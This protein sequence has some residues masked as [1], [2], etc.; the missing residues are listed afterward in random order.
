MATA[1]SFS[2]FAIGVVTGALQVEGAYTPFFVRGNEQILI[3]PTDDFIM[4]ETAE[5][6]ADP[7]LM[8]QVQ[9][10]IQ[11]MEQGLAIPWEDAKRNLGLGARG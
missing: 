1:T 10:G 5:I 4:D 2:W 11:E 9:R 7:A 3:A 8:A 6:L